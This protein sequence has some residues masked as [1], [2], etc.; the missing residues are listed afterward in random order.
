MRIKQVD[1]PGSTCSKAWSRLARRDEQTLATGGGDCQRMGNCSS[2]GTDPGAPIEDLHLS[3]LG[4]RFSYSD[5]DADFLLGG[6]P[7]Q[8]I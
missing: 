4:I 8:G 6:I 1:D 7:F 2:R 3:I 5:H